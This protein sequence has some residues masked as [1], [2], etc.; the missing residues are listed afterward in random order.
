[1]PIA[2]PFSSLK[3]DPPPFGHP[4]FA[5][6]PLLAPFVFKFYDAMSGFTFKAASFLDARRGTIH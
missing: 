1:M 2:L 5:Y 4:L 3:V 6:F